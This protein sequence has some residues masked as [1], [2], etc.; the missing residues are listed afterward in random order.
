MGRGAAS[1]APPQKHGWFVA[2]T[3]TGVGKTLISAT[4][5]HTLSLAGF[6]AAGMKPVASGATLE[7]GVWRNEDVDIL[8]ASGSLALPP[9]VANPY[10]L[11]EAAAPHIAAGL[12]GVQI[13]QARIM[14]SFGM[15]L[16]ASGALVVEGVGGFRVPLADGFDT[17]DMAQA[18]GLPLVLVVGLR[19]GCLSHALLTAE[20]IT[21][22]GL[23][24]AG[25]VGN[26]IDLDFA[27][28]GGNV[29]ALA[30]LL[31]GPLLGVV[32]WKASPTVTHAAEYVDFGAM[33]GWPELVGR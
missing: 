2:G 21:A 11:R 24:L 8:A 17:A 16:K 15:A 7:G 32:P 3:D 26:C 5:L 25:W 30:D 14:E 13:T 18:M 4:L 29:A 22:R 10:L 6:S 12:E 31:P 20:A 23:T 19:L 27:H 9:G 33:A 1:G 28:Q